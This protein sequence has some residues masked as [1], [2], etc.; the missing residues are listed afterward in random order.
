MEL[1]DLKQAWQ[2]LDR[3][4]EQRYALDLHRYR[5]RKLG[6]ARFR[7]LPVK[8]GLLL[9][10]VCGVALVAASASFW[11]AHRGSPH[12]VASGLLLHAYGL[13]LIG[14]AAWEMQL[15]SELDY[16]AP[17]LDIQ[18]RMARFRAWRVRLVPV[19][20]VTGCFVW[21]PATLVVFQAWLGTDLWR[22]APAVV[23]SLVAGGALAMVAFWAV[24]RWLPGAARVLNDSSVGDG[25]R[26]SQQALDEIARFESE[27]PPV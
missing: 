24:G 5:E 22:Q 20:M 17:V 1:D 10:M 25:V 6:S 12:L 26:R 15:L 7:L 14:S 16:A 9:R 21:I 23:L 4:L 2:S 11:W 27:A 3:R 18:R 13:L 19:W 8:A